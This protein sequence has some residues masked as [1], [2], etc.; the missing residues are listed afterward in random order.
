MVKFLKTGKR[1][2]TFALSATLILGEASVSLAAPRV[3]F[4]PAIDV[5][6]ESDITGDYT[7][8][9][10]TNVGF[11]SYST[12]GVINK[13]ILSWDAVQGADI[14]QIR[15]VD[16]AGK[17]YGYPGGYDSKTHKYLEIS[18]DSS[19][20]M[21]YD[22]REIMDLPQLELKDGGYQIVTDK[23]GNYTYP[24][25][26]TAF[27]IQVRAVNKYDS[28]NTYGAWSDVVSYT[29]DKVQK[30][31]KPSDVRIYQNNSGTY[32]L[33]F[34]SSSNVEM[35]IKD[36][37][38]NYYYTYSDEV[39]KDDGTKVREDFY[40]SLSGK[41]Y[42]FNYCDA[43][44]Y[45]KKNASDTYYSRKQ[46]ADGNYIKP[47][48][49]GEDYTIRL[50][51]YGYDEKGEKLVTD[52]TAP[53]AVKVPK[54][55]APAKTGN[56]TYDPIDN[57]ISWKSIE[58]ADDYDVELKDSDGK[59][60][61]RSRNTIVGG[62]N[63]ELNQFK[64]VTKN[65][66]GTYTEV[67]K[68]GSSI[69]AGERGKTYT[70]RVRT[71]NESNVYDRAKDEYPLQ[72]SDW[73]DQLKF[74]VPTIKYDTVSKV[75]GLRFSGS[76]LV[77]NSPED[78]NGLDDIRYEI[79]LSDAKK[80][81]YNVVGT[82]DKGNPILKNRIVSKTSV[83]GSDYYTYV[84]IDD[85]YEQ[86]INSKG[87][88]ITAFM[89]GM[90][91]YARVRMIA[92]VMKADGSGYEEKTGEWSD[93]YTFTIPSGAKSS[94]VNS[95]PAK[96]TG[97][98][99]KTEP[100][101]DSVMT[102]PTLSWNAI[103]NV[104][105]Y[106]VEVKDAAGHIFV[107]SAYLYDG[108]LQLEYYS[109]NNNRAELSYF[110]G[111]KSYSK[112][113]GS[114]LSTLRDNNGNII[115]PFIA[116]QTYTFRVRAINR[117]TKY[118]DDGSSEP[119]VEY[120]GDWSDPVSYT[121][122]NSDLKVTGLKYVKAD[123]DHYYFDLNADQKYSSLYYQV[124]TK[125]DF[126]EG[127]IWIN[128]EQ[129]YN[130]YYNYNNG[131]KFILDKD[132]F[133]PSKTYY[134]RVVNSTNGTPSSSMEKNLYQSILATASTTSFTT[135]AEKKNVAKN[136]TGLKLYSEGSD[137]FT[138]RFDAV[139]D[140]KDNDYY[141]I[142][143]NN[144]NSADNGNWST[145]DTSSSNSFSINKSYFLEG[146]YYVRVR[147]YVVDV[148]K[149]TGVSKRLYGK[150]SNVVAVTLNRKTTTPIG[151]IALSE[152]GDGFYTFTFTGNVKKNESVQVFYS[153][154]STFDTNYKDEIHFNRTESD[155]DEINKKWTVSKYTLK[156]GKTYYIKMRVYNPNAS[157]DVEKYSA[158]SNVV[159]L[160]TEMP[161]ASISSKSVTK[162]SVT[163]RMYAEYGSAWVSGYEY[164]RKDGKSWK[165]LSKS[166]ASVYTN[167]KLKA[168]KSYTYR[169]RPYYY[170]SDTKK[171]TYGAWVYTEAMP[172]W[173]GVLNL[174]AKAA[175]KTSV[176]LNWSKVKGAKGYEV[177][178]L[179]ASS[180]ST[181]E[182]GGKSNAYSSYK[183]IKTLGSG[184]KAYTDKKLV[185][186]MKYEYVVKAYKKVG[187]KKVYIQ[188][189]A[190]VNLDFYLQHISS[191]QSSNGK[192]KV[193]WNPVMSAKGYKIEKY[194]FVNGKWTLYKTIK[195]AKTSTYTLPAAT[196][197]ESY[198]L[199][200]IYAY[201]GKKVTNNI[202]VSVYPVLAAPSKV[203][204]KASGNKITISWSK[205][206]GADYYRV[207]RTT[208]PSLKYYADKKSYEYDN[209]S[210]VEVGRYIADAST[211]SGYRWRD[212]K[213][214]NVTSVVDQ[215]IIITKNGIPNQ[216][217]YKGPDT[218]V[219]YY[220][221]VVAYK[222]KPQYGYKGE[223]G[224][225]EAYSSGASKAASVTIK[226][227]KPAKPV[228]S[229]VSSKKK[230]VSVVIKGSVKAD[231]YEIYRS[232]NKKK[233]FKSIGEITGVSPTY[234]DKYNKKKNKLKKGKTY[235]YKVRA[236]V[237][238]DDGSKV[239]SAYS[240]VKK[241]KFK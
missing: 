40:Y 224:D 161:K 57:T 226:E 115:Y 51:G 79:E 197:K 203:T 93:K 16:P 141:E 117:Y 120:V 156:P 159:K 119:Y 227:S 49:I 75:K 15:V 195:K 167:K 9:K 61:A 206:S 218:G 69:P 168:F 170:D 27:K 48:V 118:N 36:S 22:M 114:A 240:S 132:D 137:T 199:Y 207:Y 196:N 241:V 223:S 4:D 63:Y 67:K 205:V 150:P 32:K 105:T 169:I 144:V 104:Y 135:S 238:N 59:L 136:I 177:Y 237:Y 204:A 147:A 45:Y 74:T 68:D 153:T 97:L 146:T 233:N 102:T 219:K 121:A 220:Y 96:I 214:M 103:D 111:L 47:F 56:L 5:I 201:N 182:S 58:D 163:I 151:T 25:P 55:Q 94:G 46:D 185:S 129:I 88:S 122:V 2:I 188:E 158:Y 116:G 10:V 64:Q 180:A 171:T 173:A 186:G 174:K 113:D 107:N 76:S 228:L 211:V 166:S 209:Y 131:Y 138:F 200:K 198:D 53:V 82:D 78:K 190:T 236:Y 239:Y 84:K 80:R 7:P 229:K 50:R 14:Y 89:S 134:V 208:E 20:G 164:Q 23:D 176:K 110:T 11:K 90:T 230:T 87:N 21:Y 66:D 193:T 43:Y 108:A 178:R 98:W 29:T 26:S 19:Y 234:K 235:Y 187:G 232:T 202:Q 86:L 34:N 70:L 65:A 210:S 3:N 92:N 38:G 175:S 13:Y 73:S 106:E 184:K 28:K 24:G 160:T 189:S 100:S 77:W 8:G 42:S 128:W 17:E 83:S 140:H 194:D 6:E 39:T 149:E 221:Y 217:Y 213:E 124:A 72:Y 95:K 212:L 126:S 143:I 172:G 85:K 216:T 37:K 35:E 127:S 125:S 154:S 155:T 191:V 71:V 181:K 1:V 33:Y 157:T 152:E 62:N 215:P 231:G 101:K 41:D 12:R 112:A 225:V 130:Y 52:W 148:N 183:L 123:D 162:N 18:Y 91:Y 109:M 31:E 54:R 30:P 81:T 44:I 142:Q 192:V 99:V 179:V 133:D 165:T 60:Y 222:N 145:I 139:L